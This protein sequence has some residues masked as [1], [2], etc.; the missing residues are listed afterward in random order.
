MANKG[1]FSWKVLLGLSAKK[2]KASKAFGIP[3]TKSGRKAK[4]GSILLKLFKF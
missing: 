1:G 4:L 2:R 3:F